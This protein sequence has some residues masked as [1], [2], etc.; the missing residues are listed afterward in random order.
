MILIANWMQKIGEEGIINENLRPEG[1][2]FTKALPI[3]GSHLRV[4]CYQIKDT[5]LLFAGG[6][7]KKTRTY[8]EDPA[9]HHQVLLVRKVG[10][11]IL[12]YLELGK[13]TVNGNK[14]E[15]KLVFDIDI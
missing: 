1:T 5:F 8:Q 11:K 13:I 7:I 4:Y 9:L 14:L 2:I 3:G 15:G 10:N 12:R 6:G